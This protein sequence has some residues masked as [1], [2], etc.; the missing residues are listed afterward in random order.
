MV[1]HDAIACGNDPHSSTVCSE[2]V[3]R[4][5]RKFEQELGEMVAT[6]GRE[7]LTPSLFRDVFSDLKSM[8]DGIGR[9][10]ITQILIDQDE[11][12]ASIEVA[13]C[14]LRFREVSERNWLT[15]FGQITAQRRICRGDRAGAPS[16]DGDQNPPDSG[17]HA[18]GLVSDSSPASS[19]LGSGSCCLTI[20]ASAPE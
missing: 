3:G 10:A 16:V 14:R 4:L 5:T 1:T 18:V 17:G 11:V 8:L 19:V 15:S 13:G 20:A 2:L 7:A 12:L 9:D 6:V